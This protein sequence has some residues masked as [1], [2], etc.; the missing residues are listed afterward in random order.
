[1]NKDFFK[2]VAIFLITVGIVFWVLNFIYFN[3]QGP[4]SR[5]GGETMELIYDPTSVTPA[6]NS[7]FN[8]T[9]KIK[10][11]V[12][13][14]LRGY[15]V[16]L[17]FDQAKL[18]LKA[19]EYKLGNVSNELG[20]TD[21]TLTTVNQMGI[22]SIIGEIPATTGHVLT[23]G[24]A[25][26]LVKLTFTALNTT[27]TSF[28]IDSGD[29]N[30]YAF[31]SDMVLF[32]VPLLSGAQFDV[33]GGGVLVSPTITV[34]ESVTATISPTITI[35]QGVS[36]TIPA[37]VT[38]TQ[39]V[40]GNVKLNLKLKFQGIG[41]TPAGNLNM[42]N[43]KVKLKKESNNA[44]Y[45]SNANF[46]ADSNGIWSGLVNFSI[47]D[48]SGK[49]LVYVKGPQHLQKKICDSTPTE[50][51]GGTYRCSDGNVTLTVGDNNLN[52][53]G[54][55]L[56]VGDLDQSGVV[57]SVDLGLVKNNLGKTDAATLAKA[58]L[59]R[60]GRVDTQDFSLILAALAIRTDE[61]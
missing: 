36:P 39:P 16:R 23:A 60:D 30:F 22:L 12:D 58:D 37:T 44:S 7:D 4:A 43:V 56:L 2:I 45:E 9:L 52:F 26:D 19:I 51:S 28:K 14:T 50:T 20:D 61:L 49:W 59:N 6:A 18:K 34:T 57:D 11:S 25:T 42:M 53:S 48:V 17:I 8:V 31:A 38:T 29:V 55:T 35:T 27:G 54:I 10:P 13:V 3:R 21:N 5:A 33:A 32:E 41:K 1:M 15:R 24:A 40:S 47:T 46:T